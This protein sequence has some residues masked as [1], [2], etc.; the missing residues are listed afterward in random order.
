LVGATRRLT[1]SALG[2]GVLSL[3]I[4]NYGFQ[5]IRIPP[6]GVASLPYIE[7]L[8]LLAFPFIFNA[9]ILRDLA[10]TRVLAPLLL[11]LIWGTGRIIQGMDQ[12]GFMA[13]RDGLPV[14]ESSFLVLGF[15]LASR[16]WVFEAAVRIF[17]KALLVV[18]IYA[19]LAP[20][21][22]FLTPFSPTLPST[23]G[24]MIPIF[25]KYTNTAMLL[26]VAAVYVWHRNNLIGGKVPW[27]P[28]AL[29]ALTLLLWPSR[30]LFLEL[31]GV[32][33][34]MMYGL[35]GS[36]KMS[37][38]SLVV[39]FTLAIGLTFG[40][41]Q[42]GAKVEGRL[43]VLQGVDYVRIVQ[44]INPFASVSETGKSLTSGGDE[45][46]EWWADILYDV[47]RDAETLTTGL[48]YGQP[49]LKGVNHNGYVTREPHNSMIAVLGRAGIV[50][51]FLFLYLSLVIAQACLRV[52][53]TRAA[54]PALGPFCVAL[55][56]LILC[57]QIYGI[58]ETPFIN[59][60]FTV[61]YYFAAGFIVRIG[62]PAR[63]SPRG[64][65]G[66]NPMT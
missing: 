47:S 39:T 28:P 32:V 40:V 55:V 58:G 56:V 59:P 29:M 7:I 31:F 30:T 5:M 24:M 23:Q 66:F 27:L 22:G 43:G 49:L 6:T 63:R 12:H 57:T 60:Y 65:G 35:P 45:R 20:F 33:V 62:L 18:V 54:D 51:L 34:L 21:A 42:S 64:L 1:L 48:G 14:L 26:L 41:L 3:A 53:R 52:I 44:E 17:P 36:R 11:W 46:L 61:P 50:G 37:R 15:A 19:C 8:A 9:E 38:L 10:R 16:R 13:V 4:F 2:L 25:F